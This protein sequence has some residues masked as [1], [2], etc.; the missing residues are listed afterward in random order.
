M[1]ARTIVFLSVLLAVALGALGW[2]VAILDVNHESSSTVSATQAPVIRSDF[3]LVDQTGRLVRDEDFS[4]KWQLIFAGFTSCPD[5]CPTTLTN[6]TAVLEELGPVADKLQPLLISVDP[7]RDTPAVMKDYLAPF[8]PRILG[9]TGTPEQVKAALGSLRVYAAKRPL[10]NNNYTM[11][12]STFI[13][14]MNPK[15][16]YTKHFGAQTPADEMVNEIR[17]QI[18]ENSA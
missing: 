5:V 15:G 10:D 14:L 17:K 12:H 2:V 18:D 11:D 4:G 16:E 3:N 8:D 7:E 6:I 13:Y 1:R 9:L